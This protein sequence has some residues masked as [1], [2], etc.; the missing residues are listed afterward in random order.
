VRRC[1]E[2]YKE[3]YAIDLMCDEDVVP[4]YEKSG[5]KRGIGMVSRNYSRQKC[6]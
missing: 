2:H 4:F 6:D 5:L 3:I 1:L